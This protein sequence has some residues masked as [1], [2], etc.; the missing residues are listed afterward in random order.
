MVTQKI[1]KTLT[2]GH[3]AADTIRGGIRMR[4]G[5][6]LAEPGRAGAWMEGARSYLPR[7]LAL[8]TLCTRVAER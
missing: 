4:R 7:G 5:Y 1:N 6:D 3:N 2:T 8:Y